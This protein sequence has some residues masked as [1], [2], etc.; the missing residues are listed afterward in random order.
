MSRGENNTSRVY[1]SALSLRASFISFLRFF[2]YFSASCNLVAQT[3]ASLF[4]DDRRLSSAF[5]TLPSLFFAPHFVEVRLAT[6]FFF[7][8]QREKIQKNNECTSRQKRPQTVREARNL[9]VL[10]RAYYV[11]SRV[12]VSVAITQACRPRRHPI[13]PPSCHQSRQPT[14]VAL[15]H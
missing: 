2:F 11:L 13:D 9:R 4:D 6:F 10:Q 3:G 1:A 14:A 12:S 8:S 5:S 15:V 7:S